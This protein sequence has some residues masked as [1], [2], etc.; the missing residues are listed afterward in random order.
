[1]SVT[2]RSAPSPLM[3]LALLQREVNQLFERLASVRASQADVAGQWLP[4]VDMFESEDRLVVVVELPGLA[5]DALRVSYR[6]GQLLVTGERRSR[7]SGLGEAVF[8][9]VERPLGR[10]RRA[11]PI[12]NAVD[13]Q[14]ARACLRDGLLTVELPRV[15]ERRKRETVIKVES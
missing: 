1:M 14:A 5:A 13:L 8:V 4:S 9:C 2:R 7:R 6:E 10:F 15:K 3:E 11:I 12:D